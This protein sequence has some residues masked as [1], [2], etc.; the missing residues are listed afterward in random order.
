MSFRALTDVRFSL[1]NARVH[2][3][4]QGLLGGRSGAVGRAF[5]DGEEIPPGTDGVLRPDHELV[6]E[7]PGGGGLFAPAE[8]DPKLVEVEVIEGLVSGGWI[9]AVR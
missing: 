3:A 9:N 6:I 8:R 1:I 5:M 4:P 7:T 2:H